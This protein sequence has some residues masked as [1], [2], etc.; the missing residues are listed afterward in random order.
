LNHRRIIVAMPFGVTASIL[1]ADGP[2]VVARRAPSPLDR[3]SDRNVPPL[4]AGEPGADQ[5]R[6]QRD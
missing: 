2:Q 1:P 5:D 4:E 6:R 3:R